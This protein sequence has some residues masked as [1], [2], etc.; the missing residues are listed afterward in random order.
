MSVMLE[1]ACTFV[2]KGNTAI[3]PSL[4]VGTLASVGGSV[5]PMASAALFPG[6]TRLVTPHRVR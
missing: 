6:R 4:E 5:V 2:L 1:G 3:M